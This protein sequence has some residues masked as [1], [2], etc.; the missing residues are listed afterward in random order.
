[1]HRLSGFGAVAT[2][3]ANGAS[4]EGFDGEWRIILLLTVQGDRIDRCEVFDESD[5]ATALARFDE[6]HPQPPRLENAASQLVQR[7]RTYFAARNWTAVAENSA[8]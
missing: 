4:P 3:Q 7:F 8:R 1:M 6:L 5:L 2:Y